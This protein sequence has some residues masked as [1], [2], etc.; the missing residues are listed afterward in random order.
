MAASL[1]SEWDLGEAGAAADG[2]RG[3]CGVRRDA[4]ELRPLAEPSP[5]SCRSLL[6]ER[7]RSPEPDLER[8]STGLWPGDEP[9]DGIVAN[10]S[11][12]KLRSVM[13][14]HLKCSLSQVQVLLF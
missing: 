8:L 9:G 1:S 13:K 6:S 5:R 4:A 11:L 3:G 10:Y 2:K 14:L 7:S 12:K